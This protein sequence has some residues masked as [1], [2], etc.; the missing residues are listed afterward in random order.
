[1]NHTYLFYEADWKGTG[2]YCDSIG[3]AGPIEGFTKIKHIDN[4]WNLESSM[5]LCSPN[6]LEFTNLFEIKPFTEENPRVTNLKSTNSALGTFFGKI[7][8][9][10]DSLLA[11]SH[12]EDHTR[13]V[14]EDIRKVDNNTYIN[15]GTLL[16]DDVHMGSWV[17]TLKSDAAKLKLIK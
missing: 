11:Y 16:V 17:I 15:H 5:K 3:T 10:E 14:V 9:V 4:M 8:I 7:I 1:V 12:T 13:V 2:T 6:T